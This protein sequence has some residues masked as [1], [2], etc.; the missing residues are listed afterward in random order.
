MRCDDIFIFFLRKRWDWGLVQLPWTYN[1]GCVLDDIF[2]FGKAISIKVRWLVYL[3]C[4][5]QWNRAIW[6]TNLDRSTSCWPYPSPK[7]ECGYGTS[8]III[9]FISIDLQKYLLI[10]NIFK[11]IFSSKNIVLK[12]IKYIFLF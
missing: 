8:N 12:T 11:I 7:D 6:L 5:G 1:G 3:F 10:K 9:F 2:L 4:K